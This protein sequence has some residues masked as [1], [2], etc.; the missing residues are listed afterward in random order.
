MPESVLEVAIRH[1]LNV[2]P[3]QESVGGIELTWEPSTSARLAQQKSELLGSRPPQRVADDLQQAAAL[4]RDRFKATDQELF[5]R[6]LL[7]LEDDNLALRQ[8]IE[9]LKDITGAARLRERVDVM[10]QGEEWPDWTEQGGVLVEEEG[11]LFAAP[12]HG[13]V[14]SAY[15]PFRRNTP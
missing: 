2:E 4:C 14:E 5:E 10:Q 9:H 12:R 3:N 11:Q 8:D 6:F 1:R 7:D 13:L 15:R